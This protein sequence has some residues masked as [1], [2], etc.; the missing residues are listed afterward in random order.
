MLITINSDVVQE[1]GH[2]AGIILGAITSLY[3]EDQVRSQMKGDELWI[4]VSN[5]KLRSAT[6]LSSVTVTNCVRKLKEYG[7]V[8][9]A[10]LE[11]D[12]GDSTNWFRLLNKKRG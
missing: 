5:T 9:T 8:E 1:V 12:Y 7:Y 6:H 11:Q 2:S 4:R 10:L 3:D